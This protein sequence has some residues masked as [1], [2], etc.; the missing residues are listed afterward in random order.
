MPA[1]EYI[2][3]H[4]PTLRELLPSTA[5]VPGVQYAQISAKNLRRAQDEGWLKISGKQK[6]YTI[7]G[8]KGTVDC[9]LYAKGKPI[10]GQGSQSGARICYV[11]SEVYK[12]TGFKNPN[13]VPDIPQEKKTVNVPTKKE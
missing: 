2:Y 11:D 9:E 3:D 13:I 1:E 12:G 5:G 8:P 4:I 10:P 7:S 6:I